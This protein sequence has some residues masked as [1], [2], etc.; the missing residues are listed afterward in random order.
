MLMVCWR[1]YGSNGGTCACSKKADLFNRRGTRKRIAMEMLTSSGRLDHRALH[2]GH[3]MSPSW[4]ILLEAI[5]TMFNL[6]DVMS[7][8]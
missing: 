6:K 1:A 8:C 3:L 5:H 4:A 2:I 7:Q